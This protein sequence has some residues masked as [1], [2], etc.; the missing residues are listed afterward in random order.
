[1]SLPEVL[2]ILKETRKAV[3]QLYPELSK[4]RLDQQQLSINKRYK[5]FNLDLSTARTGAPIGLR[6]LGIVAN[7]ATVLRADSTAY[8]H[9]NSPLNDPEELAEG[10]TIENFNI[11]EIYITNA[12]GAGSLSILV[13]YNGPIDII[14]G[15][16]A[17]IPPYAD[18]INEP[19]QRKMFYAKGRWWIFYCGVDGSY[20][21]GIY[22]TTTDDWVNWTTPVRVRLGCSEGAEFSVYTDGSSV[23]YAI[24]PYVLSGTTT[25]YYRKGSLYSDGYISWNMPETAIL[26]GYIKHPYIAVDTEG[27]EWIT[28]VTYHPTTRSTEYPF[29]VRNER[30]RSTVWETDPTRYPYRLTDMV[31][32]WAAQVIPL[33]G[34]KVAAIYSSSLINNPIN[35]RVW[36]GSKWLAPAEFTS[37]SLIV[38]SYVSAVSTDDDVH[39]VFASDTWIPLTYK[40][41]VPVVAYTKYLSAANT[42][43]DTTVLAEGATWD[44]VPQVTLDDSAGALYV[45]LSG[46]RGWHRDVIKLRRYDLKSKAWSDWA[47]WVYEP[48]ERIY[49]HDLITA[50]YSLGE[51]KSIATSYVTESVK[52]KFAAANTDDISL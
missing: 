6:D 29:V 14:S 40:V 3:S 5:V 1:M 38:S 17:A 28:Y 37:Y 26:S 33:T 52:L 9:R 51:G 49:W 35:V 18:V 25:L 22:Y 34:G 21:Y 48:V 19:H 50:P 44:T 39:I 20:N 12:A 30:K 4:L 32:D 41:I 31:A 42:F 23:W 43:T 45:Y 46:I 13:E 16:V 27:R 2:A 47:T 7:T 36:D 11:N 24:I 10:Y 15:S 8:W